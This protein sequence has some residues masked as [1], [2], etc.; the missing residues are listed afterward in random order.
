MAVDGVPASTLLEYMGTCHIWALKTYRLCAHRCVYCN[1]SAQGASRPVVPLP[2]V[3]DVLRNELAQVPPGCRI[4]IG[5][6]TD[7]YPPAEAR[8]GVTRAVVTELLRQGRT[9]GIVTKGTA[10]MRDAA[11]LA[12]AGD[13]A[14]VHVSLSAVDDAM[15]RRLE[16]GAPSARARLALVRRLRAAGVGVQVDASPWIP[17]VSDAR[18][19]LA[20]VPSDVIVQFGPLDL[21][22]LV[23][24]PLGICRRFTQAAIDA[25]YL[26]ERRRVGA[27]ARARWLYPITRG[28]DIM[29]YMPPLGRGRW[30]RALASETT[31]STSTISTSSRGSA[32]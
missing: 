3:I 18:A 10:V 31:G 32:G 16:P 9:V 6:P 11:L 19:L 4:A 22:P 23:D 20:A 5:P 15:L 13:R 7:G 29:S 26:K 12:A 8:Y 25:G 14:C 27:D 28:R 1:T 21:V 17:G 30:P 24:D 2:A